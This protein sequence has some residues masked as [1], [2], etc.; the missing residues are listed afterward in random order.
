MDFLSP[1][2]RRKLDLIRFDPSVDVLILF[3]CVVALFDSEWIEQV[4]VDCPEDFQS[5]VF[6]ANEALRTC[7]TCSTSASTPISVHQ[8]VPCSLK[9]APVHLIYLIYMLPKIKPVAHKHVCSH[10]DL[11]FLIKLTPSL[12][13]ALNLSC[14]VSKLHI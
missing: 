3:L 14:L 4:S 12:L 7:S 6:S 8:T 9:I 10:H 13:Q 2:L 11:Q 1:V 5:L